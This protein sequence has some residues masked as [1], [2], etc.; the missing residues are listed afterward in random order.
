MFRKL[1]QN[2]LIVTIMTTSL[3]NIVSFT[4]NQIVKKDNRIELKTYFKNT[5]Q[6]NGAVIL[7]PIDWQIYKKANESNFKEVIGNAFEKLMFYHYPDLKGIA[8]NLLSYDKDWLTVELNANN[9]KNSKF[10]GVVNAVF[11]RELSLKQEMDYPFI[12]QPKIFSRWQISTWSTEEKIN[13]C[14]ML[15]KDFAETNGLSYYFERD[16]PTT[17]V[18]LNN[19][20][21]RLKNENISDPS[22][23]W[24]KV[25]QLDFYQGSIAQ[26]FENYKNP[27]SALNEAQLTR[28]ISKISRIDVN[29]FIISNFK[30]NQEKENI[31]FKLTPNPHLRKSLQKFQLDSVKEFV[32]FPILKTTPAF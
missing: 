19:Q 18:I 6:T 14:S 1:L 2:L 3:T 29:E 11:K 10:K 31:S 27:I 15:I 21:L 12:N 13:Y 28:E 30:L 25:F 9:G 32:D 8:V 24:E 17:R 20:L 5:L 4:S 26:P 22:L 23:N 16:W 7:F